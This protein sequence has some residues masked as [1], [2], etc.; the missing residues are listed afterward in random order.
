M[1]LINAN[2]LNLLTLTDY[3]ELSSE[4]KTAVGTEL[5]IVDTYTAL[6]DV[7][8]AVTAAIVKVKPVVISGGG[9]GGVTSWSNPTPAKTPEQIAKEAAD[10]K[11]AADAEKAL[12]VKAAT[13]SLKSVSTS[14]GVTKFKFDLADKYWGSIFQVQLKVV[15]NGKTTYRNLGDL[16]I[17]SLDGT[18]TFSTK[19]KLVKGAKLRIVDG[20]TQIKAF[21]R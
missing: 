7:Q 4:N 10:A 5:L 6:S 13:N 2:P 11:L 1:T 9:G 20:K 14:K 8:T 15:K 17:E 21:T 16:I 12:E 18:A 19:V 3:S